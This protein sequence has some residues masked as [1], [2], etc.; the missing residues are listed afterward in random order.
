MTTSKT[1]AALT[2][3]S[4]VTAA[5]W[6]PSTSLSI[7]SAADYGSGE[8]TD[9]ERLRFFKTF[10]HVPPSTDLHSGGGTGYFDQSLVPL[11]F[12]APT[13]ESFASLLEDVSPIFEV[14]DLKVVSSDEET[15]LEISVHWDR[16]KFL[17][18]YD[19]IGV[20]ACDKSTG[21]CSPLG[22]FP[23]QFRPQK[24]GKA[25]GRTDFKILMHPG[26]SAYRVAYV[27][28]GV[29]P[30][31]EILAMSD[32]FEVPRELLEVPQHVRVSQ[33]V[34][35]S[36]ALRFVWSV[37]PELEQNPSDWQVE[38]STEQGNLITAQAPKASFTYSSDDFCEPEL[39]PA[40]STG[41][42]TPG[43]Q[44]VAVVKNVF[45]RDDRVT[46]V[47]KNLKTGASSPR[48]VVRGVQGSNRRTQMVVFG[49]MGQSMNG[50]D[51]SMQHSW[52]FYGHGELGARNTTRLVH[53]LLE[54][55]PNLTLVNHIGDISYAT[56]ALALWDTFLEQIEKISSQVS[57][58]T[59]I[60][61]HEMG[62]AKSAVP[63]TDSQGECGIPYATYFPFAG[64]T[65][66]TRLRKGAFNQ[67]ALAVRDSPWYSFDHGLAHITM[68]S[69]E[70][71]F[72]QQ[73]PQYEWLVQ[74]WAS[75]DRKKTPWVIL[76]GHRPM[77]VS[78]NF[79]GDHDGLAASLRSTLEPLMEEYGV[80]MA[81]YGHHHSYQRSCPH[82]SD[83]KCL[84]EGGAQ[85]FVVGAG[86]YAF[87][88]LS[89]TPDKKFIFAEN[90]TWGAAFVDLINATTA[91]VDY[92]ASHS[93]AVIDTTYVKRR[94]QRRDT[95]VQDEASFLEVM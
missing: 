31:P 92:H 95:N 11:G 84:S 83:N 94:V 18:P 77:Y 15:A 85:H 7:S 57:Y 87:S 42:M 3:I 71:E 39:R 6:Q 70:H 89:D 69:T 43:T 10:H 4:V 74:D 22:K 2:V 55:Y 8:L 12:R 44:L 46:Y 45:P 67:R 23:V 60:G 30:Y 88:A 49:D 38:L 82:L 66:S 75:V 59:C 26:A 86:G 21:P 40:A 20:F 51:D 29:S 72:D 41:Y 79:V 28:P 17:T 33:V 32:I 1:T 73:S 90:R 47:I 80:D 5:C 78:S 93:N 50:I 91:R 25:S 14:E 37:S 65:P 56:G 19:W 34:D 53:W 76:M 68:I 13:V 48:R 36:S 27:S 35:D 54:K 62:W 61:N 52:D 64:Q 58:M 81:F 16:L 24:S 9:A 63:S